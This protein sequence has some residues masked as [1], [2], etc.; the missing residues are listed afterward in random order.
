MFIS[1]QRIFI[2]NLK[3]EIIIFFCIHRDLHLMKIH[4][5]LNLNST[6]YFFKPNGK[7]IK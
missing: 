1:I 7:R 3:Q 6:N 2:L 5:K 4:N